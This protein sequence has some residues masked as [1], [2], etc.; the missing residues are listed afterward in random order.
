MSAGARPLAA[1]LL[2]GSESLPE[3]LDP[4]V[5]V[6][7]DEAYAPGES[8]TAAARHAGVDECVENG[9]VTEAQP[10]HHWYTE[11]GEVLLDVTAARP[12]RHLAAEEALGLR[13]DPDATV[14]GLVAEAGDPSGPRGRAGRLVGVGGQFRL[15]D[16][17]HDEDLVAVAGDGRW[18]GEEVVG[19]APRK[20][21][22]QFV[23]SVRGLRLAASF[24]GL[25]DYTDVNASASD[26]PCGGGA[27]GH[28]L[29]ESAS[30][31]LTR[32]AP[33]R[34]RA[35][36]CLVRISRTVPLWA[37][38]TRLCVSAHQLW[39]WTPRRM[40][41]PLIPVTA[42]L[43]W[44]PGTSCS[45][46]IG[47]SG[48]YPAARTATA[49]SSWRTH[50]RQCSSPPRQRIAQAATIASWVPPA[51]IIT[52]TP[53]PGQAVIMAAPTSPSAIRATRAPRARTRSRRAWW[54]GRSSITT[55]RSCTLTSIAKAMRRRLFSGVSTMSTAPL[56]AG[57]TAILCMY[58]TG[59]G[60]RIPP[61]SAAAA[62]LSAWL[63]PRET[64]LTPSTGMIARSTWSRPTPIRRPAARLLLPVSGP[65]TTRPSNGMPTS[66]SS[67]TAWPA[68]LIPALS[69]RP[70]QRPTESADVSV[71]RS[72][73][74]PR[75]RSRPTR[76]GTV[77]RSR[78][79][80]VSAMEPI[81]RLG[82][83]AQ[84]AEAVSPAT[85]MPVTWMVA[86]WAMA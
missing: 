74:R 45:M 26:A 42:M 13:G 73:S 10:G 24:H 59:G 64:R 22:G 86:G 12:P 30:G 4:F 67:I 20:P 5:L 70:S 6:A 38:I 57:P 58:A 8:L 79:W 46:V 21:A 28:R 9:P 82:A 53:L 49:S 19:N 63:R 17:S 41:P 31:Q 15:R 62:M 14:A 29:A 76:A 3:A 50:G 85:S 52:S 35:T 83:P 60:E 23:V 69:P 68:S 27:G 61:G 81:I 16:R 72:S 36:W 37:R 11:G 2:H 33:S 55:V 51:P 18:P 71:A 56:A 48:S 7:A 54:R 44:R 25:H 47:C 43:T 34:G 39:Y 40:P 65:M 66:A 80:V 84:P 78:A 1:N 75:W 32:R 77:A